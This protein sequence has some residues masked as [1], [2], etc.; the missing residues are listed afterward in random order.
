MKFFFLINFLYICFTNSTVYPTKKW[1]LVCNNS[2]KWAENKTIG[3][4][5]FIH[6]NSDVLY[7]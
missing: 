4:K 6:E 2:K 1:L 5:K 3:F 7:M